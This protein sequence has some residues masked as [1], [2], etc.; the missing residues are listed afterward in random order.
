[1]SN[2]STITI[3]VSAKLKKEFEK[4]AEDT[5]LGVSTLGRFSI[6]MGLSKLEEIEKGLKNIGSNKTL[7]D[8]C[9]VIDNSCLNYLLIPIKESIQEIE[10]EIRDIR[11]KHKEKEEEKI[12][13]E[14]LIKYN[15]LKE[16]I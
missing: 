9:V 6:R 8:F 12:K 3:K 16:I 1:M 13:K 14:S 15:N 2:N 7:N 11:N 5:K 4:Y 10:P